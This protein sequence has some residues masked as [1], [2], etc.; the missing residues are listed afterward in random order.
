MH[1]NV[2]F[3]FDERG[4]LVHW[5]GKPILLNGSV[6]RDPEVLRLLD[7][8]RPAV[9]ELF[10][11][12]L[13]TAMVHLD[14]SSCRK[15]ECNAGNMI[16][17]AHIY[18]RVRQYSGSYWTD[19]SIALLQGGGIRSSISSGDITKFDLKTILPFQNV[20]LV[21]NATGSIL[22]QMLEHSVRHYTGDRGEFMQMSGLRV[23]YDMSKKPGHRVQSA[24]ALCAQCD[25]PSFSPIDPNKE[26]G[27]IIS[28]FLYN[29][30]DG[31]TVFKVNT[32]SFQ[33]FGRKM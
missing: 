10:E 25:I 29:G 4:N 17:D 16:T 30:G 12:K 2:C 13:G 3:Q 1:F 27:V 15:S 32:H 24:E 31:Y 28:D 19:A 8:Y 21:V 33:S 22:M 18:T 14:G 20:L 7:K 6:P 23:V 5:G 9:S 26:Y 11:T